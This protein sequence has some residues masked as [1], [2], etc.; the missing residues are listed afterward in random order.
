MNN[1]LINWHL[2]YLVVDTK[3]SS[4][5]QHRLAQVLF[6]CSSC[7]LRPKYVRADSLL[8]TLSVSS[9][10]QVNCFCV[11]C[12]LFCCYSISPSHHPKCFWIPPQYLCHAAEHFPLPGCLP[13]LWHRCLHCR[14]SCVLPA[15]SAQSNPRSAPACFSNPVIILLANL[16][17]SMFPATTS[18]IVCR[19][20]AGKRLFQ[21]WHT[22]V[23]L[24]SHSNGC[25]TSPQKIY[26]NINTTGLFVKFS[27]HG[28][29]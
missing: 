6:W 8:T 19:F 17:T 4:I 11:V 24:W 18:G 16:N 14:S 25:S 3:S 7:Y 13:E 9:W 23:V 12:W 1:P 28:L 10:L 20:H 27:P 5:P 26:L 15:T 22:A 21:H 29:Q 2:Q